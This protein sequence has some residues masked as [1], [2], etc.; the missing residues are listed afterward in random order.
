MYR[1]EHS[2]YR[3]WY[4]LRFQASTED[5]RM[6]PPQIRGDYCSLRIIYLLILECFKES[7]LANVA[8]IHLVIQHSF[9]KLLMPTVHQALCYVS[10]SRLFM[11]MLF[12]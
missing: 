10:G 2:I 1:K 8:S 12:H 4:Y 5:L 3:I 7:C 11:I 9:K 6:Y